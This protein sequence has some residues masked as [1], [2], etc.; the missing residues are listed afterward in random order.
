GGGRIGL[1]FTALT[2]PRANI[3]ASGASAGTV[4]LKSSGQPFGDLIVDNR[5]TAPSGKSV[6][7]GVG[8]NT[9]TSFTSNSVT[10]SSA[11][12]AAP[13]ILAGI[14]LIFGNDTSKPWPIVTNDATSITVAPDAAFAP[15]SGQQFRGFYRFDSVTLS[16]ANVET[17]D[18]LQAGSVDKDSVSTLVTG[19]LG[20]PVLTQSLIG[21]VPTALG[22]AVAGR[23]G[24][25]VDPDTPV[26]VTAKNTRTA[27]TFAATVSIDGSFSV[28]IFGSQGDAFTVTAKDSHR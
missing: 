21:I 7:T 27:A 19:N 6:L 11:H 5:L 16:N 13:N 2:L 1:Y 26:V 28:S 20:P 3:D 8:I 18:L 25:V 15:Q 10:D 22:F 9:V 17:M 24:A 4:F 14:N 23:A 12:L